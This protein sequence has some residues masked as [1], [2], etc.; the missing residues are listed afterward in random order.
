MS[1]FEITCANRDQHG[2]IV[3]VGG[4][5]WSMP[6]HEAIVRLTSQQIRLHI[7]VGDALK[8]VGIRGAGFESYLALEPD[9]RPL[10]AL[11]DLASC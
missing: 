9:G 4:V 7:R 11:L 1:G 10:Q 6:I 8:D 5:G 3:R 2:L